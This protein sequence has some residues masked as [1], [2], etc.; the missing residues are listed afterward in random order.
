MIRTFAASRALALLALAPLSA[1]GSIGAVH[2]FQETPLEKARAGFRTE[3]TE[4]KSEGDLPAKP[5]EGIELVRYAAPTGEANGFL[6]RGTAGEGRHPAI[7]WITGGFPCGGASESVFEPGDYDNDQSAHPYRAEGVLTLYPSLR[8]THGVPGSQELFLGEVD[9]VLAALAYLRS[10]P[11]VDP[12]RVF[13]GGHS[14]GGTL[15]LL[16]SAVTNDFRAV[17]ALGPVARANDYSGRFLPYDAGSKAE[18]LVRSP[19]HHL[20]GIRTPTFVF[21]GDT[22]A[23]ADSLEELRA[24][25]KNRAV[26]Y[27]VVRNADHFS[28][29]SP[30]NR[31]LARAIQADVGGRKAFAL[32]PREC[33][34][35]AT[36]FIRAQLDARTIRAIASA[37]SR[38]VALK[39]KQAFVYRAWSRD[40]DEL[41]AV[42]ES[43]EASGFD[44]EEVVGEGEDDDRWYLLVIRAQ[45]RPADL[46]KCCDL[47]AEVHAWVRS[48]GGEVTR[49]YVE[50]ED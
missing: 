45:A 44:F 35:S 17:F 18:N 16:V 5:P 2:A 14:T 49:F 33:A 11:D 32:N 31:T 40:P 6:A 7:V 27:A 26:R 12:D 30:L 21:E 4:K 1:P 3:L 10:R 29:L 42:T 23:N 38:G 43:K 46:A 47:T 41:K 50:S 48:H 39:R 8:G 13:L 15:A 20:D 36:E 9:D 19:I 22:E 24:A 37:R 28:Y 25:S 34:D